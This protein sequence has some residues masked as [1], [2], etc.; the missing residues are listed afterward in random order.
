MQNQQ[1]RINK[2]GMS[3]RNIAQVVNSFGECC[4]GIDVAAK[5]HAM[6]FQH[7]QNTFVGEIFGAIG[8]HVLEKVCQA[9]LVIIFE[10]CTDI[11]DD[12]KTGPLLGLFVVPDVISHAVWQFADPESRIRGN[13]LR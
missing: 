3:D 5:S 4:I 9:I 2:S 13:R 10:Q 8:V 1:A 12:V 6:F 11:L 7:V